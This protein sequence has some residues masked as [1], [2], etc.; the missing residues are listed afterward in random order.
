[1]KLSKILSLVMAP[2]MVGLLTLNCTNEDDAIKTSLKDVSS[3][4]S[5]A[6]EK[7]GKGVPITITGTDMDKVLRASVGN[8][9]VPSKSFTDVTESSITFN[10]PTQAILGENQLLLVFPKNE[11]AFAT[12]EIIPLPVIVSISP[13]FG[14]D[15]D[16]VTITGEYFGEVSKVMV[17][18]T[19]ATITEKTATSIKFNVPAGAATGKITL[20]GGAAGN[21]VSSQTFVACTSDAGNSA[22]SLNLNSG[23]E[24]GT[25]D[26][27]TNWTKVNAAGLMVA[28]TVA[29]EVHGGARAVK[30]NVNGTQGGADQWRI[31]L[32]SADVTTTV[33]QSYKITGWFKASVATTIRYSTA[34]AAP[35][36]AQYQGN[37]AVNT[38]WT[39]IEWNFTANGPL[40]KISLDLGGATNTILYVDDVTMNKN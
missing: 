7:A 11:R 29:A 39:R 31:Q 38:T 25:G 20:S 17:G 9:I 40:T 27:F 1:M 30:V 6:P 34:S 14:L 26:V 32:Q 37:T 8:F 36:S 15:G 23:F 24:L 16:P 5:T 21:I 22:C 10:V 18:A 19:E 12:I 28:T 35:G 4:I 3:K 2:L 13:L 33:G